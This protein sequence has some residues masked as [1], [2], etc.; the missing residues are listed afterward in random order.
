M[1]GESVMLS[2]THLV[3]QTTTMSMQIS[4]NENDQ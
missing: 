2:P 1:L 4:T 3:R